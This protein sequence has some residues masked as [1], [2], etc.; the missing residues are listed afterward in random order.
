MTEQTDDDL[1]IASFK[2]QDTRTLGLEQYKLVVE[3]INKSN[4]IRELSNSYWI[5]VNSLGVSA[6][7]Y[8]KDASSLSHNH[9]PLVLW[10]IIALGI[11]LCLSWL[12]FLMTI[13]NSIELRNNLLLEMEKYF[14]FKAFTK[15]I[16]VSG[17]QQG[18]GSLT[19]KEMILPC[20]FLISYFALGYFLLFY[21]G[22]VIRS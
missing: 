8:I 9:K 11:V 2:D 12:N 15:S 10:F 21:Q 3:S 6:A 7:A 4:D 5:T 14:P 19:I 17:R 1:S 20:L 16:A 13:K 18:K 22:E